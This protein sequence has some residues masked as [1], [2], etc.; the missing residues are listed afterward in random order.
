MNRKKLGA[1]LLLVSLYCWMDCV[2]PSIEG[3]QVRCAHMTE[4]GEHCN[5]CHHLSDAVLQPHLLGASVLLSAEE[6]PLPPRMALPAPPHAVRDRPPPQLYSTVRC[7][8]A[9]P[10]TTF[11]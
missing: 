10:V 5:F 4:A 11:I 2:L 6:H 3:G 7:L 1:L 9:P 8:R